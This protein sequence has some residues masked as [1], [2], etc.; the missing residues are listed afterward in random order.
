MS[1]RARLDCPIFWRCFSHKLHWISFLAQFDKCSFLG[2]VLDFLC[3]F[4]TTIDTAAF[5]FS[6][7]SCHLFS[8]FKK[9]S[10]QSMFIFLSFLIPFGLIFFFF[11]IPSFSLLVWKLR[12]FLILLVVSLKIL[13]CI[14]NVLK[15]TVYLVSL[16]SSQTI[17]GP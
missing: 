5:Y 12:P 13:T 4:N 6:Y 10:C 16:P 7:L 15:T 14:I 3:Y 1:H 2:K 17:K 8:F 9:I 11:L